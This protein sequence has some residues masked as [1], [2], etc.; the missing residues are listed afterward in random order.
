[1]GNF[2]NKRY[3]ITSIILVV[4]LIIPTIAYIV[5]PYD[6]NRNTSFATSDRNENQRMAADISNMTGV[7]SDRI[8][9]MLDNGMSWNEI[10]E[11]LKN[12]KADVQSGKDNRNL[13]LLNTG[14]DEQAVKRFVEEGYSDQEITD[15]KLLAERVAFQLQELVQ[16]ARLDIPNPAADVFEKPNDEKLESFQFVAQQFD[17]ESAVRFML[18][19]SDEFGSM[20]AVLDEY[21]SA[22]QIGLNLEDYVKEKEQYLQD[23]ESKRIEI[24]GT[25]EVSL[26]EIERALLEKLHN[27]NANNL[28]E[29]HT[30][31]PTDQQQL[32]N[33]E[34]E[35]LLPDV[36][37]PKTDDV[38]PDN[39]TD[40][41]MDEI[42]VINP[43]N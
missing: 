14:L 26:A 34:Q 38:K 39:P 25:T 8:M 42:K 4:A 23:K 11:T 17:L 29:L 7:S 5:Y 35:N 13:L 9:Q 41:I 31:Q 24:I 19:L 16:P 10:M 21:L 43:N 27:D 6:W 33:T 3:K 22:L 2:R 40:K 37:M 36:P 15:A 30:V 20:E 1:V 12:N 28:D 18:E 32:G